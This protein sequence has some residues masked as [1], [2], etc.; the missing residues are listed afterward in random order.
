MIL[1]FHYVFKIAFLKIQFYL[2]RDS[3]ADSNPSGVNG[4]PFSDVSGI[5]VSYSRSRNKKENN[6]KVAE[7]EGAIGKGMLNALN[8][9]YVIQN[10][11]CNKIKNWPFVFY[12]E[13][14]SGKAYL[15][16]AKI[17]RDLEE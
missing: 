17:K 12:V 11:N 13:I 1:M 6:W 10:I 3:E 9:L 16:C 8:R 15:H 5:W 14:S 2:H 7:R 4:H